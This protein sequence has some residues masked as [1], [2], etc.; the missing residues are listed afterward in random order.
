VDT[1][2]YLA[3]DPTLYADVIAELRTRQ[4]DAGES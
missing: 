4:E 2:V 1:T 3:Q